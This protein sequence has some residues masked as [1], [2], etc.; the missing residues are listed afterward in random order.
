MLPYPS[1]HPWGR[2]LCLHSTL[3]WGKQRR[4]IWGTPA[5]SLCPASARPRSMQGAFRQLGLCVGHQAAGPLPPEPLRHVP[6]SASERG[7]DRCGRGGGARRRSSR[8]S[9]G[10][11]GGHAAPGPGA[12][13]HAAGRRRG[14]GR[15]RGQLMDAGPF[16]PTAQEPRPSARAGEAGCVCVQH[17]CARGARVPVYICVHLLVYRPTRMAPGSMCVGAAAPS[18]HPAGQRCT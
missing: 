10:H 11:V 8:R 12:R 4:R 18:V 7:A 14:C 15:Y 5:G 3:C 16:A 13:Q 6:P 1:I 17:G 2:A 9:P